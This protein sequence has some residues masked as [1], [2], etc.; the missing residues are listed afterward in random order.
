MK[1]V[2]DSMMS[3]VE[4]PE[5][6]LN[7]LRRQR[8]LYTELESLASRQR[9]LI[10]GGDPNPLLVVLA[11]RQKLSVQLTR[12]SHRLEPVRAAWERYRSQ[13][14]TVQRKEAESLL[15]EIT[16]RLQRVIDRDEE[17]AR[18]LSARKQ[19]AAEALRA[20][21]SMSQAIAAYSSA[22]G[23][24]GRLDRMDEETP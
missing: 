17:D 10:T 21:H 22:G 3:P 11:D 1:G 13:F 6:V 23:S 19:G 4:R 12:L 24:R 15:G 20:S 5:D 16:N 18:L 7:L 8:T 2:D 14:D 9:A